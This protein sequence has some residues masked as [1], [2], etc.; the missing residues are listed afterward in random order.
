[1]LGRAFRNT[2]NKVE[3]EN[4]DE[5]ETVSDE[6]WYCGDFRNTQNKAEDENMD[7]EETES[8]EEWYC[9]L[10]DQSKCSCDH[11]R[12]ILRPPSLV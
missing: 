7:E 10:C 5:E 3:D 9:G 11:R 2:Q 6:E 12:A 4:M 1:M 8:D